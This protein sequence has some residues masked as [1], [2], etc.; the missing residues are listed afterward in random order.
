M[1]YCI[2]NTM[3]K[4]YASTNI[5]GTAKSFI[6]N[7]FVLYFV[8]LVALLNLMF[9]A[10]KGDYVFCALFLL[11]GFVTAFFNKNMTVILVVTLATANIIRVLI[12]GG[13]FE[14]MKEKMSED[15]EETKPTKDEKESMEDKKEEDKPE[16][17][18]K[19]VDNVK[20]QAYELLDTQQKIIQGF[21]SIDDYMTKA[22][23]LISDIDKTAK[24]IEQMK[25]DSVKPSA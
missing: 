1:Y 15:E 8:L 4:K 13:Q 6:Y 7:K 9:S 17:K 18:A 23:T 14:G 24:K 22:G 21:E 19:L 10:I 11:I 20:T 25:N 2:I 12:R 16:M 5:A 3:A